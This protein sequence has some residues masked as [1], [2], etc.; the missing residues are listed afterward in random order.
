[1]LLFPVLGLAAAVLTAQLPQPPTGLPVTPHARRLILA[2]MRQT[3]APRSAQLRSL[4]GEAVVPLMVQMF[5]GAAALNRAGI[6]ARELS[7]SFAA[8]TLPITELGRLWSLPG[9]QRVDGVRYLRPRLDRSVPLI[10]ATAMH[11]LGLSGRGS[12]IA[13]VDTGVDFRH[14]DLRNS[15]GS[16]RIA[17]LVDAMTPRAALHPELPDTDGMAVYTKADLDDVLAAEATGH[18]PAMNIPTVDTSGHGTHVAGIAAGNGRA[19]SGRL[20]AGRYVGVAPEAALCV[21]KGTRDGASFS[22]KDILT[23]IRFCV[24][25]AEAAQQPIVVNLSLGSGGGPHDGSSALELAIDELMTDKP[26]RALV[27]ASGNSGEDDLHASGGLLNGT[28]EIPIKVGSGTGDSGGGSSVALEVFFN[29]A[30]PQTSDGI[31]RIDLELYS[32]AGKVLRSAPG[33]SNQGTFPNEGVGIIDNSDDT[34]MG[35]RGAVILINATSPTETVKS[36]EWR[37]RIKGQTLRYDVW[38]VEATADLEVSLRRHLDPDGYI[39]IPAAARTAIS[40]GAMRSRDSWVRVDG[41]MVTLAREL[42]RVA[43][44]SSGGPTGDG[45]F[46]PDILA[47]GEFIISALSSKAP[48]SSPSSDFAVPGDPSLLIADDGLHGVLRGTSQATPHVAGAIALLFELAP[49]LTG[50]QLRELLRTTA[51]TDPLAPSYGPRRGF[52]TLSLETALAALR[53]SPPEGLDIGR[54]DL[55]VNYDAIVPGAGQAVLTVTPRDPRGVPL[56]PGQRVELIS[57]AGDWLGPTVDTGHGRYERVLIAR[58]PRGTRATVSAK[59]NGQP[60][61]R[62][63]H[64]DFV[65]S[66][67]EIGSP[68]VIGSCSYGGA[69]SSGA[70]SGGLW[71]LGLLGLLAALVRYCRTRSASRA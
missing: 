70:G 23:G 56:G 19:T 65:A 52:G 20:A 35:L 61:L 3:A 49:N 13:I 69:G 15:D 1:M 31:G 36:G 48:P 55:G 45:R 34:M 66:D 39:E 12:M 7:P 32:P 68:Y 38:M 63:V 25:R 21:V 30:A 57:D 41:K 29:T 27:V 54:S 10:G 28:D 6:P 40:V 9:L 44:F 64:I 47:P 16:S 62:T 2:S 46:A 24:E 42:L 4:T 60:I 18:P 51:D 37:L 43:P 50:T 26:G 67:S 53:G 17:F 33:E 11:K 5:G 8:V 59:V 22:D 14:A 58:G 71:Q